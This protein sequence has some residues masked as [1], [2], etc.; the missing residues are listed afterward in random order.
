MIILDYLFVRP[1][2]F[3]PGLNM[4]VIILCNEAFPRG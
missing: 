3:F 1:L 4:P 2:L